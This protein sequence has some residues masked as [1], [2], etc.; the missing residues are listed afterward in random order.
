MAYV[1][2]RAL[3]LILAYTLSAHVACAEL[4]SVV[5][6]TRHGN[7][8][9]SRRTVTLCPRNKP[10]LLRYGLPSESLSAKGTLQMQLLGRLLR[11]RYVLAAP[12]LGDP[13]LLSSRWNGQVSLRAAHASRTV[14]SAEAA[15][16]ALFPPSNPTSGAH[17]GAASKMM[18]FQPVPVASASDDKRDPLLEAYKQVCS[19]AEGGKASRHTRHTKAETKRL[20]RCGCVAPPK[21]HGVLDDEHVQQLLQFWSG[22]CGGPDLLAA[23]RKR[24]DTIKDVADML[25]FDAVEGFSQLSQP[26]Q[27]SAEQAGQSSALQAL[28]RSIRNAGEFATPAQLQN[29]LG[30]LPSTVQEIFHHGGK[31]KGKSCHA[32][33]S[34][35][36]APQPRSPFMHGT[37][38]RVKGAKLHAFFGHR[39]LLHALG[40]VLG[41]AP[42]DPGVDAADWAVGSTLLLELHADCAKHQNKKPH[43]FVRAFVWKP[44]ELHHGGPAPKVH[45]QADQAPAARKMKGCGGLD[46]PVHKFKKVFKDLQKATGG[47]GWQSCNI[48]T[49][50]RAEES[51][52]QCSIVAAL[53]HMPHRTTDFVALAV[54]GLSVA[55]GFAFVLSHTNPNEGRSGYKPIATGSSSRARGV[56]HSDSESAAPMGSTRHYTASTIGMHDNDDVRL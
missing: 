24:I 44:P 21:Q 53:T 33:Q 41:V 14:Q 45:E 1:A 9:P 28:A 54:I 19:A 25:G 52:A 3:A 39:E 4:L 36:A 13:P 37:K 16:F 8:V 34:H 18:H 7:R 35:A 43:I 17:A 15:A 46:C 38:D 32:E 29:W 47:A 5:T 51:E 2:F 11:E 49:L 23:A 30:E 22:A 42:P 48:P 20:M 40:T 55:A 56:D 6:V 10:N 50:V 27:P 26:G 31:A 12:A